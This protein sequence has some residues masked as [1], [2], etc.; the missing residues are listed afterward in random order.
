M[1]AGRPLKDRRVLS[2]TTG[3]V[4]AVNRLWRS[5]VFPLQVCTLQCL[6]LV[7]MKP[8]RPLKDLRALSATTGLV[9]TVNP[10]WHLMTLKTEINVEKV[11]GTLSNNREL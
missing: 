9:S 1:K 10:F 3:K 11:S 6:V 2:A 4:S 5:C 7:P 8:G